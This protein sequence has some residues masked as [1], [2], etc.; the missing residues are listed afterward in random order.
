M[1]LNND[2]AE[3]IP[4]LATMNKVIMQ[5]KEL[6]TCLIENKAK[7]DVILAAAIAG[8]WDTAQTK[9]DKKKEVFN[10]DLEIFKENVE[11]EFKRVS[12]KIAAK[13]DLPDNLSISAININT[14]LGLQYP[15][16]HSQDYERAIRMMQSSIF[17][18]VCLT[19]QE[20]DAYVLNNWT[21]K[22][23]F[24]ASNSFYVDTMRNKAVN[25]TGCWI[26]P[27]GPVGRSGPIGR[28]SYDGYQT[29]VNNAMN[30][31]YLSG[32]ASF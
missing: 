6:L 22:K 26:G 19:V 16:D 13:K 30:T 28:N 3:K 20:Y 12:E 31:V 21:W 5:K 17:E 8:Y 2:T 11:R 14:S 4:T 25:V 9:M 15:E 7:H 29:A 24:L 18:N 23:L 10:E 1:N 27:F 32:C